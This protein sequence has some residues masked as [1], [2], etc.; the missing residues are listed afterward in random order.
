MTPSDIAVSSTVTPGPSPPSRNNLH[1]SPSARSMFSMSCDPATA[2]NILKNRA[3]NRLEARTNGISPRPYQAKSVHSERL[4]K[5][6]Y[7]KPS[8]N[9]TRAC[10]GSV[11]SFVCSS[12]AISGMGQSP[13]AML[14]LEH[15]QQTAIESIGTR[16]S[17]GGVATSPPLPSPGTH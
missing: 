4:P 6:R 3:E 11:T 9:R 17:G 1:S 5:I 14:P 8:I 15:L 7:A 12:Q 16:L 10:R 13:P 2:G